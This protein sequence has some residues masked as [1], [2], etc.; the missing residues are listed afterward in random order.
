MTGQCGVEQIAARVRERYPDHFRS[1]AEAL[2]RVS[3][4]SERYSR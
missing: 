4:L 3:D 1:H 2:T